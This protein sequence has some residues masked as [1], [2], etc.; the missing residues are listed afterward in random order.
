[1]A[2][3][4][5]KIAALAAKLGG[6]ESDVETDAGNTA[7]TVAGSTRNTV[8]LWAERKFPPLLSGNSGK[9]RASVVD[10]TVTM[11]TRNPTSVATQA[12]LMDAVSKGAIA[13]AIDQ[14]NP[15]GAEGW[16]LTK[17]DAIHKEM[18]SLTTSY[19]RWRVHRV[20]LLSGLAVTAAYTAYCGGRYVAI[21]WSQRAIK[22]LETRL[23]HDELTEENMHDLVG[24]EW[25]SL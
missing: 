12:E 17:H 16:T 18:A 10:A 2:D 8:A 19:T 21:K 7:A 3:I 1:M 20:V 24:L 6:L 5:G 4:R 15:L 13:K 14:S 11:N 23:D 25:S 22:M 9:L